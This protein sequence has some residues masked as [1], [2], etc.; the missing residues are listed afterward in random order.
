[1]K[2]VSTAWY[3]EDKPQLFRFL[4]ASETLFWDEA[5]LSNQVENRISDEPL[6]Q[7]PNEISGPFWPVSKYARDT[8][9]WQNIPH[10]AAHRFSPDDKHHTFGWNLFGSWNVK[11]AKRWSATVVSAWTCR[12]SDNNRAICLCRM[13]S[14]WCS[15]I[16]AAI[17]GSSLLERSCAPLQCDQCTPCT[18]CTPLQQASCSS[19]TRLQSW[20][21]LPEPWSLLIRLYS[22]E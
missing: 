1:M 4:F 7:V 2:P 13:R 20:L 14:N 8:Q 3:V 10:I 21:F 16:N 11:Y 19:D 15:S 9:A 6:K 17:S 12:S 18:K 5:W 22:P